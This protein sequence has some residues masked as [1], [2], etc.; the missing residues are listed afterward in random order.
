VAP[1]NYQTEHLEVGLFFEDKYRI[2]QELGHGGFGKVYLARQDKM[3]RSV[4]I[5]V[6]KS[7][8]SDRRAATAKERFMR[9]VRVISNLRHPNTVTIH[10]FGE[11]DSGVLYMVLEY[12]EGESLDEILERE[13]AQRPARALHFACQIARSLAEAHRHGVVHREAGDGGVVAGGRF[14]PLVLGPVGVPG[15]EGRGSDRLCEHPPVAPP[16][17]PLVA[18]TVALGD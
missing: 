2:V 17:A 6:L 7:G 15:R 16:P 9:E 3:D 18:V 14:G 4:A 13:G 10:D 8:L 1:G 11:S 12:I 5:K